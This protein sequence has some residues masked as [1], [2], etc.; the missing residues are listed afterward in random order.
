MDRAASLPA[1]MASTTL[2]GPETT[3]PPAKTP[4]RVVAS[5][6]G[7]TMIVPHLSDRVR[8]SLSRR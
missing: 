5:V 4:G 8:P 3:S 6:A 2:L 7:S 1:A